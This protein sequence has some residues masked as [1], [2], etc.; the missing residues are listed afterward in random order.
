VSPAPIVSATPTATPGA[1]TARPSA[2]QTWG[3]SGTLLAE[4][5]QKASPEVKV[6]F[7]PS[8]A[9]IPAM[10][11]PLVQSG[12]LVMMLGAGDIYKASEQLLALLQQG[13]GIMAA[14]SERG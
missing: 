10:L 13:H 4:A 14:T 6:Q 9:E 1:A 11:A 2:Y 7:V 8:V 12:D 3:M 5:V